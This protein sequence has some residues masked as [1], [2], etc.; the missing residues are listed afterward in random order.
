[1]TTENRPSRGVEHVHANM[2]GAHAK[3]H[4]PSAREV[5]GWVYLTG[6]VAAEQDGDEAGFKPGFERAFA[7]IAEVLAMAGC[8]WNDVVSIVSH[9]IDI[10]AQLADM[11]SVKDGYCDAAPYPAWSIVG[12]PHLANPRGFCEIIV[13]ARKPA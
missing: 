3:F 8:V 12:T 11:A 7:Q 4:V 2:A 13:V 9:H 1:M 10:G 6:V 5:D